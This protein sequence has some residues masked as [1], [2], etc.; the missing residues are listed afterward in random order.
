VAVSPALEG[1]APIVA[2]AEPE[3]SAAWFVEALGFELRTASDDNTYRLET[4]PEGR[5]RPP[6]TQACGMR[7][8]HV[9]DPDGFLLFFGDCA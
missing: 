2:V 5:V 8:F 4:L 6:F 3:A 9:K 7:E 1:I